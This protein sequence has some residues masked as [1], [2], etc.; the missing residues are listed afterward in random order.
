M[1]S[2]ALISY[3]EVNIMKDELKTCGIYLAPNA[4]VIEYLATGLQFLLN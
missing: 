2:I 4:I 3:M 1:Y